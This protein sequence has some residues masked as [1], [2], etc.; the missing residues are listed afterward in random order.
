MFLFLRFCCASLSAF[1]FALYMPDPALPLYRLSPYSNCYSDYC[2]EQW[3]WYEALGF[4]IRVVIA[5]LWMALWALLE[6]RSF[7]RYTRPAPKLLTHLRYG[8]IAVL[9][10]SVVAI[11]ASDFALI[12]Y[13]RWRIVHY[14]YSD[15]AVTEMPSLRLYNNDRG[16]CGNGIASTEYALYGDTPAAY[17]DDPDPATRARALQA[18]MYVYDWINQ[19]GDG[20]SIYA[21]RKAAADPDPMVREV[22]ARYVEEL[23]GI[24][25]P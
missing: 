9:V 14:I 3:Y 11:F 22:A 20:P 16:W 17:I 10:L 7:R 24:N 19:P 4:K 21:L 15:A 6:L 8:P 12:Q 18:A 13:S 2:Q 5:V 25:M 23:W 1:I